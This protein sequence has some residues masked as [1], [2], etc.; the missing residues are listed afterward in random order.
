[1]H[2]L[3]LFKII[4]IQKF[5]Y[6]NLGEK[7]HKRRKILTPAFHF[8][9]L[10]QFLNIF[11]EETE[12]LIQKLSEDC[13]KAIDV[14]PPVTNFTL[15]SIAE[16]AMGFNNIDEITQKDYKN[17]IYNMGHIFLR[18]LSK[19]WYRVDAIYSYSKLAAE[20]NATVKVLHDFSNS[21]IAEREKERITNLSQN[22][23][24]YS[25]K[26][27]LA[28]LDLLLSAKNEGADIDYEGIREEVDTFMFEVKIYKF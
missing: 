10:Q 19:P 9:I 18:R 2:S 23:A 22:L 11:N 17:A 14:V 15:Q 12:K 8:N 5:C 4:L 1:M 6:F 20:E 13:G 16:T 27:R 3:V 24:S 21:I 7:W 28:M 25:K 26:K